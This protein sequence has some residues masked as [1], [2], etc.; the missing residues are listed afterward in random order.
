M[1]N[2]KVANFVVKTGK[3]IITLISTQIINYITSEEFKNKLEAAIKNVVENLVEVVI[4][5]KHTQTNNT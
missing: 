1:M 5:E 4:K 3:T 2:K